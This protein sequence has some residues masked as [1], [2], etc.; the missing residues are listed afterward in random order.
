MK[1][2][3]PKHERETIINFNDERDTASIWTASVIVYRR[4]LK[5]LGR[6]YLAE[7]SE[8]HAEFKFPV[9]F[10]QLPRPKRRVTEAQREAGRRRRQ[11]LFAQER[12]DNPGPQRSNEFYEGVRLG[13]P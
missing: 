9:S 12:Q 3:G 11:A 1:G 5:R 10:I 8:R 4:L 13:D 7:D 6:E 2:E